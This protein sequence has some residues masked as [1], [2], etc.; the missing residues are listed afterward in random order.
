[1]A[2]RL[3]RL[4]AASAAAARAS[5]AAAAQGF[6]GFEGS[7]ADHGEQPEQSQQPQQGQGFDWNHYMDSYTGGGGGFDYGKYMPGGAPSAPA[8]RPQ[9]E[10]K[11]T[12]GGS[13]ALAGGAGFDTYLTAMLPPGDHG[14]YVGQWVGQWSNMTAPMENMYSAGATGYSQYVN[15]YES[16]AGTSPAA[17]GSWQ[18]KAR[19]QK[20][21]YASAVGGDVPAGADT[22]AAAQPTGSSKSAGAAALL[23]VGAPQGAAAT[24]GAPAA[25]A[26]QGGERA[27]TLREG[28]AAV[29]L[30]LQA[31]E[32]ADD[33]PPSGDV[34]TTALRGAADPARVELQL[35]AE[36][37]AD[38][39]PRQE[40]GG[41]PARF[42]AK[43]GCTPPRGGDTDDT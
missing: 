41:A 32:A 3:L 25:A 14:K 27:A 33:L 5:A 13:A 1:M 43:G 26:P 11:G 2:L 23:E 19:E 22:H 31:E 29:E 24:A 30:Q 6:E 18:S 21:A 9:G 7:S 38:G 17:G 20:S 35:P 36:G 28:P 42:S 15:R 10:A 4:G 16:M 34:R 12:G 8:E 40:G 39:L 37:A